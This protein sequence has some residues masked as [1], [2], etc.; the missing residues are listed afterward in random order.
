MKAVWVF[1]VPF[2]HLFL[3][4]ENFQKKTWGGKSF[5][6]VVSHYLQVRVCGIALITCVMFSDVSNVYSAS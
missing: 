1:M 2:F 6:V 4:T 3:R 5:K